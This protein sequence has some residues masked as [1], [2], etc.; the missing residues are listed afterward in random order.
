MNMMSWMFRSQPFEG[1]ARR[2]HRNYVK[3]KAPSLSIC[4][5]SFLLQKSSRWLLILKNVV[6]DFIREIFY[7]DDTCSCFRCLLRLRTAFQI[8]VSDIWWKALIILAFFAGFFSLSI[9]CLILRSSLFTLLLRFISLF[10]AII[11]PLCTCR[12]RV[13]QPL[14]LTCMNVESELLQKIDTPSQ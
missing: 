9:L 4:R 10:K 8:S 6:K 12:E 1:E 5:V 14:D 7:F 3:G 2:G 13:R 11:R